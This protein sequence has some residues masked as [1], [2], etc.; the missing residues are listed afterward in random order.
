MYMYI[1]I[2]IYIYIYIYIYTCVKI[3]GHLRPLRE[4]PAC[5]DPPVCGSR[6]LS[7]CVYI[8]IYIYNVYI[9]VY[10]TIS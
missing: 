9:H 10:D 8:Y 7:A 5:P 1:F 6:R 3:W 4:N 2:H